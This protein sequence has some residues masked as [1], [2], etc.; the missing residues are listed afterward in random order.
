MA[1]TTVL[2]VLVAAIWIART[3]IAVHRGIN[4]PDSLS[5]HIPFAVTFAQTGFANQ[6]LYSFPSQGDQFFPANDELLSA[7]ALVLTRS[8]VFAVVKN[9]LFGGFV[10]VAA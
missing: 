1:T 2:V 7:I 4:D 9:L 6:H 3:I 10:L 5:Y 8:I